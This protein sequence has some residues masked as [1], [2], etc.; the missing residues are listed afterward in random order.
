MFI[1][2]ICCYCWIVKLKRRVVECKWRD[3]STACALEAGEPCRVISFWRP[4]NR[5]P[6]WTWRRWCRHPR[7]RNYDLMIKHIY[8]VLLLCIIYTLNWIITFS[9][10]LNQITADLALNGHRIITTWMPDFATL[11]LYLSILVIM[12]I[13]KKTGL[14]FIINDYCSWKSFFKYV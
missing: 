3:W 12:Q 14:I 11:G 2:N 4:S 10:R 6:R 8:I 9:L 7:R 5:R 1:I 13:K